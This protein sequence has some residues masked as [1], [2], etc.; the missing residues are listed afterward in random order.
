MKNVVTSLFAAAALA[1]AGCNQSD[2]LTVNKPETA[3]SASVSGHTAICHS[4][5]GVNYAY[6][7]PNNNSVITGGH[8]HHINDFEAPAG[9]ASAADCFAYAHPGENPPPP[10]ANIPPVAVAAAAA[11]RIECVNH[12]GS[13][14]LDGSASSDVDGTIDSYVWSEN[15]AVVATGESPTATLGLGVHVLTLVVTD[16]DGATGSD[17]VTVTIA[18]NT[19]P[20]VSLTVSPGALWSPNHKY[21]AIAV[22]ARATDACYSNPGELGITGAAVSN[23]PDNTKGDGNTSGDVKVTLSNGTLLLS[24]MA[25]P[26]VPFNA[27]RDKLELRSERAGNLAD[28]I[29]ALTLGATDGAGN[30]AGASASVV[31]PHNQ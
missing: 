25:S 26:S 30:S 8:E 15:G 1:L 10:T 4:G 13:V 22:S 11:T 3:N 12:G 9:V 14:S 19:P 2:T 29:Y 5:N 16:N 31:V 24:S 21:A 17:E 18:D 20:V 23:E 27:L 28:R 7:V 6:I